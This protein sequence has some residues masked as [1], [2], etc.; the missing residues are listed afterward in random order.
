MILLEKELH[1][2]AIILKISHIYATIFVRNGK[3]ALY[4][5]VYTI[6]YKNCCRK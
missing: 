3:I 5:Y 4:I 2:L 6:S 1:Y